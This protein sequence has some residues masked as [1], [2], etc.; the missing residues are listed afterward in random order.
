MD[1]SRTVA[2]A[3][4]TAAAESLHAEREGDPE[5]ERAPCA[6]AHPDPEPVRR[7]SARANATRFHS[8][9]YGPWAAHGSSV[10]G[11]EPAIPSSLAAHEHEH[12]K[13]SPSHQTRRPRH[14]ARRTPRLRSYEASAEPHTAATHNPPPGGRAR[15]QPPRARPPTPRPR[16]Q[17]RLLCDP[18]PMRSTPGPHPRPRDAT[19]ET[20]PAAMPPRPVAMR[21]SDTPPSARGSRPS[22]RTDRGANRAARP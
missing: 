19:Q 22:G 13:Y 6:T 7:R 2:P 4:A 3:A 16:D 9:A 12:D 8:A 5:A 14:Q 20:N 18:R 21:Q 10:T 15:S 11:A 1:G 17:G